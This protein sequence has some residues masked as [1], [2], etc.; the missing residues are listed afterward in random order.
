MICDIWNLLLRSPMTWLVFHFTSVENL[1]LQRHCEWITGISFQ[2]WHKGVYLCR[3]KHPRRFE[4]WSSPSHHTEWPYPAHSLRWL[5]GN[6]YDPVVQGPPTVYG[7][8]A[9][10]GKRNVQS[11]RC[12]SGL[13]QAKLSPPSSLTNTKAWPK[14]HTVTTQCMPR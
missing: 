4:A 12:W 10:V 2:C 9:S 3:A 13:R 1:I 11:L 14:L 8:S 5:S 6:N 7:L